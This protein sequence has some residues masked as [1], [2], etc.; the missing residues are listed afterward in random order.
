MPLYF[1]IRARPIIAAQRWDGNAIG[2]GTGFPCRIVIGSPVGYGA[3]V[4]ELPQ[5]NRPASLESIAIG[6]RDIVLVFDYEDDIFNPVD[7]ITFRSRVRQWFDPGRGKDGLRWLELNYDGELVRIACLVVQRDEPGEPQNRIIVDLYAPDPRFES[8]DE[9]T[10]STGAIIN[11]GNAPAQPRISI[12]PVSSVSWWKV[13]LSDPTGGNGVVGAL[14]RIVGPAFGAFLANKTYVIADNR[15]QRFRIHTPA[16]PSPPILWM[17]VNIPPGGTRD[18]HILSGVQLPNNPVYNTLDMGGVLTTSSATAYSYSSILPLASPAAMMSWQPSALG[19]LPWTATDDKL[20][21]EIT[22]EGNPLH[23]ELFG[24]RVADARAL[25]YN[26]VRLVIPT[27]A[28]SITSL[29]R[30]TTGMG[31]DDAVQAFVWYKTSIGAPKWNVAW[32]DTNGTDTAATISF[33]AGPAYEVAI[34]IIYIDLGV[35]FIPTNPRLALSPN[36][37]SF[38]VL[39]P[40]ITGTLT[41]PGTMGYY[42]GIIGNNTSGHGITFA[43]LVAP[44]NLLIDTSHDLNIRNIRHSLDGPIM[45]EDGIQFTDPSDW[46][47]LEPGSNDVTVDPNLGTVS[48]TFRERW[49]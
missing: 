34:G 11:G 40:H 12:A 45:G 46:F 3:E 5:T 19:P 6:G 41:T 15:S 38:S 9:R 21:W 37:T 44:G 4:R 27:G 31:T 35:T 29:R 42:N 16:S 8:L 28:T 1:R 39:A 30:V 47:A 26:A 7:A 49:T 33:G 25:E 43:Q 36:G 24:P 13:T 32:T 2:D 48:L 18:V 14:A 22:N 23:I 20:A 10:V 17:R